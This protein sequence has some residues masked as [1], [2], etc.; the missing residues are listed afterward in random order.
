M[1]PSQVSAIICICVLHFAVKK[2]RYSMKRNFI[3]LFFTAIYFFIASY[4]QAQTVYHVSA[5]NGNDRNDGSAT[6][7]FKTIGTASQRSKPG[8]IINVHEGT[9]REE[10]SPAVGGSSDKMR[11]TYQA[12]K[13]ENVVIKGSEIIKGWEKVS[14]NTWKANV[15]NKLFGKFNP[16]IDTIRGD[17]FDPRK[18]QHH[19]GEVYLDEVRLTEAS[20]KAEVMKQ[21]NGEPYW[22]SEVGPD[23]TTIWAQF[24]NT[25]PN[26]HTVEINVRQSIFYPR[27]TGINYITVRGFIMRHAATPWAPP[28]AEQIGLIGTN[29]S[30]GW[31]IENNEI[32]DSKC[33][34]IALGKYGDEWDNKAES[35]EGYVGTIN[36][37]LKNGW[38][39]DN[40]GHHIVRNN[41][42]YNCEQAG[43]V[44]SLG[45]SFSSVTDNIIY[46]T[47]IRRLFTGAE[48]SAIK[49]HGAIDME[50]SRNLIYH[51]DRGIWLD[52]MAQ[53][54]RVSQN[55]CFDNRNYD[56]FLEVD[57]GPFVIDNNIFLSARCQRVLAQGGTYAHNLFAGYMFIE[58]FDD[59]L[60]PFMKPHSTEVAGLQDNPPGDFRFYNNIFVGYTCNLNTYDT[61]RLPLW[62]DGNVFLAGAKPADKEAFPVWE[63]LY[64]PGL[65]VVMKGDGVYLSIKLDK[66]WKEW[67]KRRIVR[68]EMLGKTIY[69]GLPFEAPDGGDLIVDEDYFGKK[70]DKGNPFPGPFE[71]GNSSGA[72]QVIKVW[73]NAGKS[74]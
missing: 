52:W 12:A 57:H 69:S 25:N 47:H 61:A 48:M 17:W 54:T 60:T 74:K 49:F 10:I 41:K 43:I 73:S 29:W 50:I 39:K 15:S 51:N 59:R 38:N 70:R 32:S 46:N 9:Y 23:S 14:D 21:Q 33:S 68:T 26:Q 72:I 42:I 45:C 35:A 36:R 71:W 56:L 53:G 64:N 4:S 28:T 31:I 8:D 24:G 30:K 5:K 3:A 11:I 27:K 65:G 34:G 7:P 44:G 62:M 67:Q 37:A 66:G 58:N 19:T 63:Q 20:T 13:N 40:I 55:V 18:R 22:F 1:L 6:K 16:Y 2:L